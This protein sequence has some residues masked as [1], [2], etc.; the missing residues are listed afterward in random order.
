MTVVAGVIKDMGVL[1]INRWLLGSGIAPEADTAVERLDWKEKL[2]TAT[3]IV[4]LAWSVCGCEAGQHPQQKAEEKRQLEI[5]ADARRKAMKKRDEERGEEERSLKTQR[6]NAKIK[7]RE[8]SFAQQERQ[9]EKRQAEERQQADARREAEAS[10][11]TSI[12]TTSRIFA[13]PNQYPPKEFAAYGILAFRS[14]SSSYDRDRHLM[15]CNAYVT[16]LPHG[17]ELKVASSKQMDSVA[18]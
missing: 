17:S 7:E 18:S 4:S 9:L 12:V 1:S 14:R 6:M 3:V 13:G 5:Q 11:G 15:I 10:F 2:A 16:T 8:R